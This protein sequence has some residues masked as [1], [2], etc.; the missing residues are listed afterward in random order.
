[1]HERRY[2]NG[3]WSLKG[4]QQQ[5]S[6]NARQKPQLHT[7]YTL[8]TMSIIKK[9]DSTKYWQEHRTTEL[10]H[11]TGGSLKWSHDLEIIQLSPVKLYMHVLYEQENSRERFKIYVNAI[12]SA[13]NSE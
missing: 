2:V 8:I 6:G 13:E 4:A 5:S 10:S 11:I 7:N 9:P 3:K 1:M 12:A